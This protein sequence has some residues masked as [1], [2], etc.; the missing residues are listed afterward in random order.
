MLACLA[1]ALAK[2]TLKKLHQLN[3]VHNDVMRVIALGEDC[4]L[5]FVYALILACS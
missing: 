4:G 5:S 2:W 1:Q 3:L